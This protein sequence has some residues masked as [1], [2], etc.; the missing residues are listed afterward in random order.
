MGAETEPLDRNTQR[1]VDLNE[2]EQRRDQITAMMLSH[3]PYRQMASLLGVGIGTIARDVKLIRK[4]WIANSLRSYEAHV[5]DMSALLDGIERAMGPK[6]LQGDPKAAEVLMRVMER[7]A[8]LL[9]LDRPTKIEA[10]VEHTTTLDQ[11]IEG[12]L[13]SFPEQVSTP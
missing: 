7:R 9:G 2:R 4:R 10:T 8:R 6:A 11:A 5:A 13:A 12:L 1:A 3:T